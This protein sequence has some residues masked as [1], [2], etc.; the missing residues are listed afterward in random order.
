M[1]FSSTLQGAHIVR[2]I[3]KSFPEK[4]IV[5]CTGGGR[6][7]LLEPSIQASD[8][9]LKKDAN[10]EEWCQVLDRSIEDLADPVM[11][12][13]K[14]RHRLLDVGITPYQLAELEDNFVDTTLRG[15][16]F[17]IDKLS[18]EANRLHI[19]PIA[20]AALEHVLINVGFE[21]VRDYI[22]GTN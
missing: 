7:E 13:Q 12:W 6:A 22:R 20:K 10:V 1:V 18:R 4:I 11:V 14:L 9:F 8:Y 3:K 2:E 15:E 5:V 17:S 21:L 19:P 16:E